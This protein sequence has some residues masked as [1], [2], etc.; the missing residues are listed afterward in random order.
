MRPCTASAL[1]L[2]LAATS[3]G[4]ASMLTSDAPPESVYW[5]EPPNPISRSTDVARANTSIRVEIDAAPGLDSDRLLIR[6]PGAILNSYAGARWAD[7]APEVID[8]LIRTAL[9]DSDRFSR[10]ASSTS[11]GLTDWVLDLELRAFYAVLTS[12][13]S[14]PTI[15]VEFRGY[16]RCMNGEVSLRIA[17]QARVSQI[18][19]TAIVEGF[20]SAMDSSL[21]DLIGQLP[22]RCPSDR[23]D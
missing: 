13:S 20:Q 15:E 12:E 17:N 7:N 1:M 3:A 9:E 10:V 4:C 11:A 19:L 5:L 22:D 21:R 2:T 16:L 23:R 18:T 14:P 6:G 8:T